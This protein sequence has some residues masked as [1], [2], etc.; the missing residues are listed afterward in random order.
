MKSV[1][2]LISPFQ[3][4]RRIHIVVPW[5]CLGSAVIESQDTY[6]C[7]QAA[8]CK[9]HRSTYLLYW[10]TVSTR[11]LYCS[12]TK[13]WLSKDIG[14]RWFVQYLSASSYLRDVSSTSVQH[15]YIVCTCVNVFLIFASFV[16]L[17]CLLGPWCIWVNSAFN[18]ILD[19][20]AL[21]LIIVSH[22]AHIVLHLSCMLKPVCFSHNTSVSYPEMDTRFL[23]EPMFKNMSAI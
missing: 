16:S 2:I 18:L 20:N 9:S 6:S 13:H 22:I 4:T 17:G 11:E 5:L 23:C 21:G 3:N 1:S 12:C 15:C 19:M 7:C 14:L 8:A 10:N